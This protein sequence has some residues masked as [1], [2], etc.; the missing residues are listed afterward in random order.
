MVEC[1]DWRF[2]P[3][4]LFTILLRH[5]DRAWI[6]GSGYLAATDEMDSNKDEAE[7]CMELAERFMRERKYEDAE[8]FARKAQKLYPTKKVEGTWTCDLRTVRWP[9]TR[10]FAFRMPCACC[11]IQQT[12]VLANIFR[13]NFHFTSAHTFPSFIG[14]IQKSNNY[15]YRT[16][17]GSDGTFEAEPEIRVS[18]A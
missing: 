5:C 10:V 1:R 7:R 15:I 18:W 16:A 9:S 12:V 2:T 8:K 11:V 13:I 6:P 14:G 17:G 4:D 3:R